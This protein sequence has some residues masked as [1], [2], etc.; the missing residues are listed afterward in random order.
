MADLHD[1]HHQQ[2]R[3][4]AFHAAMSFGYFPGGALGLHMS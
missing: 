3:G 2:P 1:R 4:D